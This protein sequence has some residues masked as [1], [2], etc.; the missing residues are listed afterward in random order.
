MRKSLVLL[1][2]FSIL[3]LV[4]LPN[5]MAFDTNEADVVIVNAK[6][7]RDAY[8]GMLYGKEN[9]KTTYVLTS[10]N[11][12][13]Q[14][15]KSINNAENKVVVFESEDPRV[16]NLFEKTLDTKGIDIKNIKDGSIAKHIR[17]N[18]DFSKLVVVD[19]LYASNSVAVASYVMFTNSWV[20]FINDENVDEIQ[21][22]I[23]KNNFEEVMFY[24]KLAKKISEDYSGDKFVINTGNRFT[25]NIE[26][27]KQFLKI[28]ESN[29][30]ILADGMILEEGFFNLETPTLI[31]GANSVPSDVQKF[32]GESDFDVAEAIG[33]GTVGLASKLK[34]DIKQN[35]DKEMVLSQKLLKHQEILVLLMNWLHLIIFNYRCLYFL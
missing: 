13:L 9:G 29:K 28:K 3:L 16:S 5:G 19:D 31:L 27:I 35:Y 10:E 30:I 24:G 20:V 23:S 14:I 22:Y 7:W 15:A 4:L 17:E 33:S 32:I 1:F 11:Q 18:E 34:K 26:I 2:S 8:S 12:A 6:D 21:S 25:N